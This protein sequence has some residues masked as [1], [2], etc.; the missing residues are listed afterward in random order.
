VAASDASRGLVVS[1]R[2][3]I[4]EV[5]PA[6]TLGAQLIDGQPDDRAGAEADV[7]PESVCLDTAQPA[8]LGFIEVDD[9]AALGLSRGVALSRTRGELVPRQEGAIP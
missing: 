1:L 5:L 7:I 8:A 4:G 3:T 2:W 9:E 6:D